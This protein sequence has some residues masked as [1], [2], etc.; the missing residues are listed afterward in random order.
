MRWRVVESLDEAQVHELVALYQGEWWSR[1]R[2]L[3]DVR[4][5][6][7]GCDVVVGFV[8]PGTDQLVG[9]ARVVTDGVFKATVYDVIVR[10][11]QRGTGLGRA[12]LDAIVAHPLLREVVHIELY[13]LPELVAFY[14]RWGFSTDVSG[15]VLMRRHRP[16]ASGV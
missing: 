1:G 2:T 10:P 7:A 13:C 4:R 16:G 11:D 8:E 5:M 14:E 9:F 3:A 12:I 6:L 15:S